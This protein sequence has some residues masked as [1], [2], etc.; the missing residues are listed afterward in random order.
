LTHSRRN[1]NGFYDKKIADPSPDLGLYKEE[2][3]FIK[4]KIR[5]TCIKVAVIDKKS[6]LE[7]G[8]D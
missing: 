3:E 1:F 7:K 4:G 2:L 5:V 8:A 6:I